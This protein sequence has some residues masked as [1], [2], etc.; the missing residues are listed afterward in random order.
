MSLLLLLTC[1]DIF[2]VIAVSQSLS[3]VWLFETLWTATCQAPLSF[4]ISQVGSD[5]FLLS[6]W[7]YLTISSSTAS[8]SFAFDLSQHQGLFQWV[9]SSHQVAK[10][11][12]LQLQHQSF[13]WIFRTDFLWLLWSPCCPDSALN[14]L[15]EQVRHGSFDDT[16]LDCD[17]RRCFLSL[18]PPSAHLPATP[19]V[20]QEVYG[21][22]SGLL[23]YMR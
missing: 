10:V 20:R 2:F 14:W 3:H 6:W 23:A 21:G 9:S 12:E 18:V 16:P 11:L 7:Y 13:Q 17:L 4:T 1:F 19:Q 15:H 8:F 5:S 22:W